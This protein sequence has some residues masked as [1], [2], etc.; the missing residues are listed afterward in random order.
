MTI[1]QAQK[2]RR[3]MGYYE[4]TLSELDSSPLLDM[5]SQ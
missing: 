2:M 5:V 4:K 1:E 3:V